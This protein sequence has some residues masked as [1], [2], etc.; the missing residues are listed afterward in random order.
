MI[1][2]ADILACIDVNPDCF[3]RSRASLRRPQWG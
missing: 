3:H 1:E 2:V